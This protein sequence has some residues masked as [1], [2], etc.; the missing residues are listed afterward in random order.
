[1][2]SVS[3]S[4]TRPSR[5]TH[6]QAVLQLTAHLG[7]PPPF[8]Q[9]GR[10]VCGQ[11]CHSPNAIGSGIC[12]QV[13]PRPPS[14]WADLYSDQNSPLEVIS[15]VSIGLYK[16]LAPRPSKRPLLGSSHPCT[17]CLCVALWPYLAV[18]VPRAVG[19]G[20]MRV[21]LTPLQS[22]SHPGHAAASAPCKREESTGDV[23]GAFG[24]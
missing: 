24:K 19:S 15:V 6:S 1:M 16:A 14:D 5:F 21:S 20:L 2:G 17:L 9:L 12:S 18:Q 8:S 22:E 3:T 4:Q 10:T 7:A 23:Q 13:V 11:S